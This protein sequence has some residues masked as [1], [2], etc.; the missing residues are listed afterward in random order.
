VRLLTW[1]TPSVSRNEKSDRA[2]IFKTNSFMHGPSSYSMQPTIIL[3]FSSMTQL[4]YN[5]APKKEPS[6]MSRTSTDYNEWFPLLET[7]SHSQII[8]NLES[9][10]RWSQKGILQNAV[11]T[12]LCLKQVQHEP[13][14]KDIYI[15]MS[16]FR[17]PKCS[18]RLNISQT[19]YLT[20]DNNALLHW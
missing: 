13:I 17:K 16:Y 20:S 12:E 15:F 10:R 5:K 4:N 19:N 14:E 18:Y 6:F 1:V 7:K 2:K 8:Q 9:T 11:T 3:N